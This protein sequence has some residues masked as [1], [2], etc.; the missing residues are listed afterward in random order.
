MKKAFLL[1]FVVLTVA[2]SVGCSNG[3]PRNCLLRKWF[4]G[5]ECYQEP[6]YSCY[7]PETCSTCPTCPSYSSGVVVGDPVVTDGG[8][9]ACTAPSL[10]AAAPTI[11]TPSPA[12][13]TYNN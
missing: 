7:T 12:P 5:K 8:C 6:A 10:P 2:M 9:S 1:S 13:Y 4:C 3:L 11:T